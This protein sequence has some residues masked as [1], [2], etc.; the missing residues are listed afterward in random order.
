MA[1]SQAISILKICRLPRRIC[2]ALIR[3]VEGRQSFKKRPA[4]NSASNLVSYQQGN[5]LAGLPTQEKN[6]IG[7]IVATATQ[8]V[9]HPIKTIKGVPEARFGSEMKKALRETTPST[10]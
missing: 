10:T 5:M 7:D 9:R 4:F 2:R 6:I 8:G 1:P 3:K